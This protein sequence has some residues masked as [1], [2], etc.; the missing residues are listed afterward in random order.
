MSRPTT[1][2]EVPYPLEVLRKHRT[3]L[4]Q[5]KFA[6]AL[7]LTTRTYERWVAGGSA[8]RLTPDQIVTISKIC[9]VSYG[10]FI[11][12]LVGELDVEELP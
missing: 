2:I 7:G 1:Q 10:D 6:E 11:R 5:K 8:P 12:V 9:K 3:N 4:S